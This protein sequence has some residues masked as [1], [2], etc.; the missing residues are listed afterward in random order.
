MNVRCIACGRL[1]YFC[2]VI[3]QVHSG[4]PIRAEDF[5]P[6]SDDVPA[7]VEGQ[8]ALCPLCGRPFAAQATD[9]GGIVLLLEGGMWWPHPPLG[10]R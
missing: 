7:P 5:E 2:K 6:L 9:S 3:G 8:E 4:T 10:E 1:I